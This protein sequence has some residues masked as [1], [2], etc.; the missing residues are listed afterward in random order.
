MSA[1]LVTAAEQ[2][3][4][5]TVR[6]ILD[7]G[8]PVDWH[9]KS[10]GFTALVEAVLHGHLDVA[11]LLLERGANPNFVPPFDNGSLLHFACSGCPQDKQAAMV[12]LL[13]E[14]GADPN[15]ST[16]RWSLTPLM[17]A[18]RWGNTEVLR[19]LLAAGADTEARTSDGRAAIDFAR[20][21]SRQEAVALL[22]QSQ[23]SPTPP[24]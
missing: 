17:V 8:V 23:T 18:A 14:A 16:V 11:R 13:L 21:H 4:L 24:S 3:K 9:S 10:R 20:T 1:H 19:L 6:K 22:E 12:T 15:L 7:R 5:E 2:G